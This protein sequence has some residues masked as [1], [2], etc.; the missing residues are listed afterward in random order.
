MTVTHERREGEA[1]LRH[2]RDNAKLTIQ[3]NSAVVLLTRTHRRDKLR[4]APASFGEVRMDP[5]S[6][7]LTNAWLQAVARLRAPA[8]DM[9]PR[10]GPPQTL[11]DAIEGALRGDGPTNPGQVVDQL[12]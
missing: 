4:S 6:T 8:T 12:A 11:T 1:A 3:P 5:I 10:T 2:M 7:A 9:P